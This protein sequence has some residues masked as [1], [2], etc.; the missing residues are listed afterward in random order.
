MSIFKQPTANYNQADKPP[1]GRAH[2]LMS[3]VMGR[4]APCSPSAT[5]DTPIILTSILLLILCHIFTSLLP[6]PLPPINVHTSQLHATMGIMMRNLATKD[7][8]SKIPSIT[9]KPMQRSTHSSKLPRSNNVNALLTEI[10]LPT[11]RFENV[12]EA[13]LPMTEE[14]STRTTARNN[15]CNLMPH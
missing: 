9:P 10:N 4:Q 7:M 12:L 13:L 8:P 14:T 2:T 11:S 6:S 5:K 1:C 15:P 3:A